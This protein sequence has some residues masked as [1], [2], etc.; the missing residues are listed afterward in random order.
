MDVGERLTRDVLAGLLDQH[1]EQVAQLP[2]AVE[3]DPLRE[4]VREFLDAVAD[5]KIP[6]DLADAA[7]KLGGLDGPGG[8]PVAQRAWEKM[9]ALLEKLEPGQ[10][11][12]AGQGGMR[13]APA[14]MRA[15]GGTLAQIMQAMNGRGQGGGG[16]SGS[17]LFGE[18]VG[19]YGPDMQL[20]GQQ[21]TGPGDEQTGATAAATPAASGDGDDPALTRTDATTTV[22]LQRDARF[23]LRYRDLVGD[24]FRAVAETEQP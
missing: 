6:A 24:Y 22:R 12:Q 23:P 1:P 7:Q 17:G 13:F 5:A 21:Q 2:P 19:L 3:F 4:Q 20:A 9:D 10:V 15:M 14:V 11:G 16:G 8:H 18:D